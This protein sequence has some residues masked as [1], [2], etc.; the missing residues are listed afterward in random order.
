MLNTVRL[1]LTF[2]VNPVAPFRFIIF[3]GNAIAA[4]PGDLGIEIANLK[5]TLIQCSQG[6]GIILQFLN[7]AICI[8][9]IHIGYSGLSNGNL[10]CIRHITGNCC[11]RCLAHA[12]TG[13]QTIS[14]NSSNTLICHTPG[15]DICCTYRYHIRF[16]LH[17]SARFQRNCFTIFDRYCGCH[18]GLHNNQN[19]IGN[20]TGCYRNICF[21]FRYTGDLTGSCV[22]ANNVDILYAPADYIR[23][24]AGC[25]SCL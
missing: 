7:S 9:K 12:F 25:Y 22:H 19:G 23:G 21:A 13:Q 5:R 14:I 3:I 18:N 1:E 4:L 10:D 8:F 6:K 20:C 15:N 2:T 24:I 16:Q 17:R 11:Y